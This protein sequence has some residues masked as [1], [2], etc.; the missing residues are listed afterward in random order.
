MAS[1]AN[2][3]TLSTNLNVDP[4][5]DDF[6]EAKNFHRILFR[7]GLAVQA[8]EL[9]QMQ[10]IL[11]NQIDRFAEHVFQ[12]GSPVRGCQLVFD[13]EIGYV[14]L[15]NN[16]STGA[17]ITISN[18]ANT[19]IKGT[20]SGVKAYVVKV[21]DGA[22]ANTP[23]FKTLFV[24]YISANTGGNRYFANNEILT[25]VGSSLTANTIKS[26]QGAA[27]GFASTV[28]INSGVVYAKDHF[29]RVPEQLA[30]I[31]KY[32]ANSSAR[33][34]LDVVESI[35]GEN[36]DT[37]LL[38][39][40]SGSYNYVAPGAKRLKLVPTLTVKSL[41]D[42]GANNFIE[43]AQLKDGAIQSRNDA[44]EYAAI[45]DYF[46]QR[47]FDQSGNFVVRGLAVGTREHLRQANNGGVFLSGNSNLIAVEVQPGKAY[48]QGYDIETLSSRYV[49]TDKGIDYN[50]VQQT[51]ALVDYGNYIICDNVVG[52]WDVN[53][54]S[55]VSLRRQQAN[56]ISQLTYSTGS[57]PS[58]QIGTARVRGIE[59]FSG[60]PG[61]PS[62]QYKLYLTDIRMTSGSFAN[63][64]CVTYSAGAGQANGKAD[65]IM[66][67]GYNAN[68]KDPSFDVALYNLPASYI[69]RLRDTSGNV[70]N[71][72]EF[73]KKFDVTFNASGQ[74]TL[75][76]SDSS[77]TL[78]GTGALS[79]AAINS[80]YYVVSRGTANTNT[81]TGTVSVTSGGNT[82]TGSSTA[83]TS[84]V[85]KGDLILVFQGANNRQFVVDDVVSPTSLNILGTFTSTR[86]GVRIA[87]QFRPGQVLGLSGFGRNGARGITVSGSPSTTATL[88]LNE[89]LNVNSSSTLAASVVVKL[90]KI[91]GQEATKS[92]IR[93]RLVQICVGA[94][95]GTS[96]IA[97]TTGP[98]PI[99]LSDGLRL[100][101][102]R[103]KSGSNFGA[104]SEGVDVTNQFTLDNGQRDNLYDHARLVKKTSSG[105]SIT[106]GDRLLVTLDH[107]THSNR[108]RG[109]FSVDSYPVND[110]T[111][112]TDTT[113]IYTY[114]I[115]V[116]VSPSD[117]TKY[118]LRD[119]IDM[120]PRVTDTA[121]SVSTVTNVSINPL[122]TQTFETASGGFHF[123][124]PQS[125][126]T[127]DLEYYLPRIDTVTISKSGRMQAIRGAPSQTPRAPASPDDSMAIAT[128]RIAPY[129]SLPSTTAVRV[130]RPDLGNFVTPIRN[131]RYTMKD[132]GAIR[133]RVDHLEY[134]T[135]LS[136]LEKDA[137]ALTIQ[138]AAGNDRFKNG[139]LVDGFRGHNIGNVYDPDYKIAV[140]VQKGEARPSFALDSVEMF[141]HASASSNVVRTNVTTA[142][143]SRD[144]TVLISNSQIQFSNGEIVTSGGSSATLR[145]QV[146]NKLYVEEAT[147]NFG[148]GGTVVG[149]SSGKSGLISSVATVTPGD[150]VT[151]P[152]THSILVDQA[153]A[154]T[155][156][157]ATS[158][159]YNWNG[160]MTLTPS[161]DYWVDT[162]TQ[163]DLQINS[164]NLQ[165]N[166]QGLQNSY[167]TQWDDWQ[168]VWTGV[169][170]SS[171]TIDTRTYTPDREN[172][173]G[174]NV[175]GSYGTQQATTTTQTQT[176]TGIQTTWVPKT[177][178]ERT[179]S[180]IKDV[181][182]QPY[183]RSRVIQ[184]SAKGMKPNTK[185]YAFFDDY[186]VSAYVTPTNSSFTATGIEGSA[187]TTDNTGTVYGLF[188][189]PS[190]GNLKFK[191]GDR[192]FRISDSVT[193]ATS[194]G[195][196][197][198]AAQATYSAQG[199]NTAAQDNVVSTRKLEPVTTTV[200]ETRTVSST[201]YGA[202]TSAY[203]PPYSDGRERQADGGS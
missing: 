136:L 74:A 43:L 189:I 48:V 13:K 62:A 61:S 107:F 184:F 98:W 152:Y 22:E 116:F 26:S 177:S 60:T 198:T 145:F 122:N 119:H 105:L 192:I 186:N 15:R 202:F 5:Y 199:L 77:E 36:D 71:Q 185:L 64:Q 44:P 140:D 171:F 134:Y 59:Y 174:T 191:I 75:N 179:G 42:T 173:G 129:P 14:K 120:R 78:D 151:L 53:D 142:G 125:D 157:P 1:E 23:D 88:S 12:E 45:K 49:N 16:D 90:N 35:I 28:R 9:T 109:Y 65:I 197:A 7:P 24:K 21:N 63:V 201:S 112:G 41:T 170:D 72:F 73:Y 66:S 155:T 103:K 126:F 181:N 56:A 40:A 81:L 79:G 51:N 113:K 115:P 156:R 34:G 128:V 20:T 19:T 144:Q 50:A 196:V 164:N 94:G 2:T 76:T 25:I 58:T 108:E 130:G 149:G 153:S 165:D 11:Q 101:S 83:F 159:L 127:T 158:L 99:G 168:T 84:Q 85:N 106:S 27:T 124:T 183:M 69:R 117:G 67:N 96:Y 37:T 172:G 46:A 123:G 17:A 137:T 31:S 4:F 167:Q 121:N 38:D 102:V 161:T 87:K 93:N 178:T 200:T 70:N 80:D 54:Q 33:I 132:I 166:W 138:D 3:A 55:T 86:N 82:V 135:S 190:D 203:Q 29:I 146:D 141:Y 18:F 154:T 92:V 194:I 95:G 10:T 148:A 162:T 52:N 182:V 100:V 8:R 110:A 195:T 104:T 32:S 163:P 180:T 147:G 111:A 91:D 68:T 176:R 89:T 133:D 39:P 131:E 47:T 175:S 143:V 6:D 114:Q 97:N 193:N 57:L 118:D 150:L 30:V 169:S 160:T 187:L 139:I 188:R